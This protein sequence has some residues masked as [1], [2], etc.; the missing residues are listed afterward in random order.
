MKIFSSRSL[1]CQL[2]YMEVKLLNTVWSSNIKFNTYPFT[3]GTGQWRRTMQDFCG[4]VYKLWA[5]GPSDI[6]SGRSEH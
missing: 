1:N 4:S 2:Q 5:T 3:F 6:C